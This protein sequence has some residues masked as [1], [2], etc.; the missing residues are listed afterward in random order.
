MNKFKNFNKFNF[1]N[2]ARKKVLPIQVVDRIVDR[3]LQSGQMLNHKLVKLYFNKISKDLQR[4]MRMER[5]C[6]EN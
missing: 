4:H 5:K 2:F 3:Y 6:L 1:F